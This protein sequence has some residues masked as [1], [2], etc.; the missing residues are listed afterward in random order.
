M[1]RFIHQ[2]SLVAVCA[3]VPST[4]L[5]A[6]RRAN[7][8]EGAPAAG[9]EAAKASA[10]LTI[11]SRILGRTREALVSL[12]ASWAATTRSYPVVVVLDG[13]AYFTPMTMIAT[14]LARLGH[15]PEAI[16]VAIPNTDF[17]PTDRLHDM[18][19]PGLSVSGSSMNEGGDDFLDFIEQ[20][21]LPE[22]DR[23]YR[24]GRPRM[25]VGHSSGGVIATWAAATRPEGFP[26]VVS[27]DAPIHLQDDWQAHRLLERARSGGGRM[28]RYVS[29]DARFGWP[30]ERW[31]ELE[32]AAPDSWLLRREVLEGESHESMFFLAAYQGLKHAFADY[33]I[34]GA[35]F[36][37]QGTAMGVFD[38]FAR[39]EEAFGVSLPPSARVLRRLVE[40]LLTE[41]RIEPARRALG[42]LVDGYGPPADLAELEGQFADV[43]A[44]LP[45]AETVDELKATP[46]PT[47]EEVAPYL[48]EW[49]GETWMD[50]YTRQSLTLRIRVVDGRVRAETDSPYGP[51]IRTRPVEYLKVLPG[52]L[53][54]GNMNGMR[55]AGMLVYSG[56]RSGDILEGEHRFRGIVLPLPG[57]HMP[58]TTYFRLERR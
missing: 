41:G 18:T 25:L 50:E 11:E 12:P 21:L 49:V 35:P 20:E 43:Q 36:F 32:A 48:G 40:D 34:V 46:M 8:T 1:R 13:E 42:W 38:H 57:G 39:I 27:I 30:E 51:E 47:P 4:P 31:R 2:L 17:D 44:R 28:L 22:V 56:R 26:V 24:G 29:V 33:S 3:A 7:T 58:R 37:P 19:P 54:F 52:G 14:T 45:L 6:Q 5:A 23:R 15:V 16:V 55:P 10:T 9:V 53:E